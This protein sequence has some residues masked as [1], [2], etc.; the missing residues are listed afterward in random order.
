ESRYLLTE[1]LPDLFAWTDGDRYLYDYRVEGALLRFSTAFAN[2]GLG[3]LELRGGDVL[4]SGNQE[5]HQRVY[6]DG[7]TYTD[8]LAGEFTY[9][10]SHGHIHF[11]G[12]AVYNLRQ[13]LPG[14]GVGAIVASSAKVSFCLID[15]T[16]FDLQA[17]PPNYAECEALVQGI[18]AGWADVYSYFL[19][20]Q[21]VNIANVA[22]G[23]YWLEVITDPNNQ[24]RESDESNN[25]TR[26][27]VTINRPFSS[28]G[29]RYEPN[30]SFAAATNLGPVSHRQE[31][32]LS[33]HKSSDVDYYRFQAVEDGNFS[34]TLSFAH[35]LGDLNLFAYDAAQN[36]IASSVTTSDVETVQWPALQG[37]D[38]YIRV[39]GTGSANGY[40]LQFEG[41][42]DV[43]TVVI[44]SMDANLPIE[45]P[46]HPGPSATSILLAP[47]LILTDV[48]LILDDLRHMHVGDLRIRLTS[49]QGTTQTL[50][51]SAY[52]SPPGIL[53][54]RAGSNHFIHTVL[55]DQ[56][57]INL[58]DGFAPWTGS[59]NVNHSSLGDDLLA[60]FNG[61]NAA[62]AWTLT[63][64]DLQGEDAG[65]LNSWSLQLTGIGELGDRFEPNDDF[66]QAVNLGLPGVVI[67]TDLSIHTVG[68]EDFFRMLA[69]AGGG[70]I[71]IEVFLN[72]SQGNLDLFL[73]NAAL[74][75]V[76]RSDTLTDRERLVV[77]VTAGE[78]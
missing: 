15:V 30:G 18:S 72:H 6:D 32:G 66:A 2:Q 10:P 37:E 52:D 68:D 50:I 78:L 13:R 51:A 69:S 54:N 59:F 39:A 34:I 4:P 36:L 55:D 11:D 21:W 74:V 29:D 61:Q 14:N 25:T 17:G 33:I 7:G 23:N 46:D 12:Y 3:N 58:G 9:H 8:Y 62:G 38:Y 57:T 5:V 35:N 41:P 42:G 56:A 16:R 65:T 44:R 20:D 22:D 49:P 76:A 75:E 45:I 19:P 60:A 63:V 53:E 47:D 26:I 43:S 27:P 70:L 40:Q 28:T 73:Y 71:T 67:Q 48:N 24:L 31:P 1:L 64:L 77:P